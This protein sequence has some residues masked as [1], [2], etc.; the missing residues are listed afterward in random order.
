MTVKPVKHEACSSSLGKFHDGVNASLM[1]ESLGGVASARAQRTAHPPAHRIQSAKQKY[2]YMTNPKSYVD[3]SLFGNPNSNAIIASASRQRQV[4]DIDFS[5]DH[6]L[7]VANNNS[8][9]SSSRGG[10]RTSH[11]THNLMSNKT[12]LYVNPRRPRSSSMMSVS[13]R[14]QQIGLPLKSN[15]ASDHMEINEVERMASARLGSARQNKNGKPP[16]QKPWK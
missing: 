10:G 12:P 14:Q 15:D 1:N 5:N 13:A 6:Y 7:Q 8:R 2:R 3:E 4:E 16:Y 11:L 9:P